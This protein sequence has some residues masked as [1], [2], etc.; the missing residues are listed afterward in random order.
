MGLEFKLNGLVAAMA[1]L[2]EVVALAK[3]AMA[4]LA[5]QDEYVGPPFTYLTVTRQGVMKV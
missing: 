1:P 4:K 2:S 3:S 5:S